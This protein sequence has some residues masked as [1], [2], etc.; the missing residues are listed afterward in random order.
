MQSDPEVGTAGGKVKLALEAA[1]WNCHE[2][3]LQN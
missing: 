3:R 2:V 1:P